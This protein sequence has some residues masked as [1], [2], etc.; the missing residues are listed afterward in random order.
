[1]KK[2]HS[3]NVALLLFVNSCGSESEHDCKN[4][5][6][7]V[8]EVKS[9]PANLYAGIVLIYPGIWK[10]APSNG[11]IQEEYP[12]PFPSPESI[13]CEYVSNEEKISLKVQAEDVDGVK[14]YVCLDENNSTVIKYLQGSSFAT[15]YNSGQENQIECENKSFT[16]EL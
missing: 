10:K 4:V 7:T 1:M 11:C 8:C 5:A 14:T 6:E 9:G 12:Q 15:T 2:I 3:L 16:Y 13:K